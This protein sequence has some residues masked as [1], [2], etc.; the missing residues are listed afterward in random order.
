VKNA[1]I[2]G[3]L[4]AIE[5]FHA[6][7]T[8]KDFHYL[9]PFQVAVANIVADVIIPLLPHIAPWTEKNGVLIAGGII[10]HRKE[11]VY[12]KLAEN[13]FA[14]DKVLTDGEWVTLAAIKE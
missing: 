13:N 14:V 1:R 11:E 6:D 9:A 4:T 10:S 8:K 3:L 5:V 7:A 12:A 2:N